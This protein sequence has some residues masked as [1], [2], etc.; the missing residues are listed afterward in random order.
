MTTMKSVIKYPPH[1]CIAILLSSLCE[2][3]SA[4][5]ISLISAAVVKPNTIIEFSI[6]E[7]LTSQSNEA[8][9]LISWGW[10]FFHL[11]MEV[12]FE[13]NHGQ[14]TKVNSY[15]G[16]T[17][18]SIK[19]KTHVEKYRPVDHGHDWVWVTAEQE[20]HFLDFFILKSEYRYVR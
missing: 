13:F 11:A 5:S 17:K 14:M 10:A 8:R 2:L 20:L 6:D 16:L 19:F 4:M 3:T 15:F 12:I 18:F 7:H 9:C 1:I